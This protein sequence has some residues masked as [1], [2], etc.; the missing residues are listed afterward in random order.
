MLRCLVDL[1]FL[2]PILMFPCFWSLA[3]RSIQL[4]IDQL[5]KYLNLA[6]QQPAYLQFLRCTVPV[7]SQF[8]SSID[9]NLCVYTK[10]DGMVVTS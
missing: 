1:Y 2:F 4:I 3:A 9:M 6:A 8:V 7:W 10:C 5:S